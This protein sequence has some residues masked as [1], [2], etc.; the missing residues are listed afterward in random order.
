MNDA[1]TN[2]DPDTR[3]ILDE[4]M[5]EQGIALADKW[6]E[7]HCELC[8]HKLTQAQAFADG[9]PTY[10]GYIP[11]ACNRPIF[12]DGGIL[13]P[14]TDEHEQLYIQKRYSINDL[15]N[16]ISR[17]EC[18]KIR[19]WRKSKQPPLDWVAGIHNDIDELRDQPQP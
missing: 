11:C 10:V 14:G 5:M 9:E 17:S 4:M 18:L 19:E 6:K 13:E 15:R 3:A 2:M 16:P 7:S 8:G 12:T 1:Y